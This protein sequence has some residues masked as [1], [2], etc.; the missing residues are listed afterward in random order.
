MQNSTW[1]LDPWTLLLWG[2]LVAVGLVGL[3]SI[4]HGPAVEYLS[5]SV[6]DNF[7]RQ[8]LWIGVSAVGIGGT[9]LLPVRVLRY[10][11]YPA[12]VGTLILL[13]LSLL[14]GVE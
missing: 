9:L 10:A 1:K 2:G 6:Q 5:A 4:T 11:A 12:Y 14:V 8:F 13:V 3:Y 7:A